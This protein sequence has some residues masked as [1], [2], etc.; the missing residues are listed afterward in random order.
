MR[1]VQGYVVSLKHKSV[2]LTKPL[3]RPY[4]VPRRNGHI[5]QMSSFNY[6]PKQ[7]R[8]K[9]GEGRINLTLKRVRATIVAV[10]KQ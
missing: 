9:T 2:T 7:R 3:C 4:I 10:E 1:D 8:N 6:V 5:T